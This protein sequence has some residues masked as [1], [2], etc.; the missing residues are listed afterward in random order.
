MAFSFTV[1]VLNIRV[2]GRKAVEVKPI[3]L[4]KKISDDSNV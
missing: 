3:L 2:R 4:S 1:E